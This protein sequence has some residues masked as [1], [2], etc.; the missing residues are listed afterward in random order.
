[1]PTM[2]VAPVPLARLGSASAALLQAKHAS[3]T[4]KDTA[5]HVLC[6]HW[7]G[8]APGC[9]QLHMTGDRGV[10]YLPGRRGQCWHAGFR[11]EPLCRGVAQL[12]QPSHSWTPAAVCSLELAAPVKGLAIVSRMLDTATSCCCSL[13]SRPPSPLPLSRGYIDTLHSFRSSI[14]FA[15]GMHVVARSNPAHSR[16]RAERL[17]RGG[18]SVTR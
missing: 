15:M 4:G 1:M 13:N 6:S 9:T 17:A 16:S 8:S 10:G 14:G 5:M 3:L 7:Q 2:A 11:V 18:E 12:E